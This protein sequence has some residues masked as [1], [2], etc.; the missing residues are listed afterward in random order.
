MSVQTYSD[1]IAAIATPLGSGGVGILRLSGPE[2]ASI[3]KR[4]FRAAG[5][6]LEQP[7]RLVLGQMVEE[8]GSVLDECLGVWMPSPHSYTGEDVAELQCHGGIRLLQLGLEALLRAG[9][10]LAQ[11]GEFTLRAFLNGRMDLAQ[12]EAVLDLI[13]AKTPTGAQLATAQLRG[14]LSQPL[15]R[16]EQELTRLRAGLTVAADFPD[17]AD[18]PPENQVL[19]ELA[20]LSGEI[21]RLLENAAQGQ[22]YREGLRVVLAGAANAG[23][24][25]LLNRL[26]AADRAIVTDQ[27]G[28]T[29]DVISETIDLKG[30]PILLTD[31]AGLRDLP[32][33]DAAER[34]GVAR[35]REAMSQAQLLLLVVDAAQPGEE[36]EELLRQW[37]ERP[38]LLLLNKCDIAA[39]EQLEALS[40]RL[41]ELAPRLTQVRLSART[42]AGLEELRQAILAAVS[43]G[44]DAEQSSPLVI[45]AR[46]SQEL[47]QAQANLLAAAETITQGL[48]LDLAGVDLEEAAFHL[49]QISGS[50]AGEGLLDAI[51]SQ[52]CL[53]K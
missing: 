13:H 18:A 23:K 29:R 7:R 33:L 11:P 1:T 5:D 52:F 49:G 51:F 31:T 36:L 46:H 48:P 6:P 12:A 34:L 2:T 19:E 22:L 16:L 20:R 9:A 17:D 4:V 42:G 24:S 38:S 14:A 53:G 10:R 35:S 40:Q 30:L 25:S 3:L 8:N 39:P 32:E 41:R 50:M 37:A 27:A 21:D 26:L 45:N 15:S 43:S 47:R 28:T 44:A